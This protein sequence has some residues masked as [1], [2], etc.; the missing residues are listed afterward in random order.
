MNNTLYAARFKSWTGGNG[1]AKNITWKDIAFSNVPFPIYVTQN[2]WDQED[3]SRPNSYS[4][5]N[6]HVEDFLFQNFIGTIEDKPFVEGSCV[7]D[8][9]WYAIPGATGKEVIIFDLYPG[10]A[11]NILA[12]DI[13]SATETGARV[14]VMCNSTTVSGD[15]GFVC[16]D[17]PFVPTLKGL[18]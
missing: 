12:K 17:G 7:T 3:G 6:T 1:F 16:Q 15:V 18:L 11:T 5:N 2:Y 9:C 10:T 13:F 8:P 14:A 4:S